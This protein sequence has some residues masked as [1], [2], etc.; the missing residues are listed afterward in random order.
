MISRSDLPQLSEQLLRDNGI[1]YEYLTVTVSAIKPIQSDR[2]PF[3]DNRYL[4]RYVKITNDTY[5][6]L[7]VDKDFNLIDGHHRYDI[8]RRMEFFEV[9]RVLQ[10]DISYQEVIDLFK[11]NS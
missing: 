10:L 8:M 4:E 2:L 7:I 1:D 9:A 6:P 5:K 11:N 3:D